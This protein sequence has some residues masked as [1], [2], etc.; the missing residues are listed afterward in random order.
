MKRAALEHEH[1]KRQMKLRRWH[2]TRGGLLPD[3]MPVPLSKR[4]VQ[5]GRYRKLKAFD[6]GN[7]QCGICHSDKFPKRNDG[8]Q[9]QAL[10]REMNAAC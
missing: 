7:P 6:C 5:A 9:K 4:A 1:C 8:K 3:M 10:A 2:E